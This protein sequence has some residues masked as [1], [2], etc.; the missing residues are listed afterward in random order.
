MSVRHALVAAL[1][2][3]PITLT[4]LPVR[5]QDPLGTAAIDPLASS[6]PTEAEAE[7]NDVV[8]LRNGGLLRGSILEV[9]PDDSLMQTP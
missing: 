2:V 3:A 5:A 9:L 4:S 6:P 8:E 1:L 7:A